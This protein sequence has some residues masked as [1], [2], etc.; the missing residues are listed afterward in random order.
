MRKK[1][2]YQIRDYLE[3]S[4]LMVIMFIVWL[5]AKEQRVIFSVLV[6]IFSLGS[7]SSYFEKVDST[8]KTKPSLKGKQ[9]EAKI[10]TLSGAFLLSTAIST[11]IEEPLF[12]FI[13]NSRNVQSVDLLFFYFIYALFLFLMSLCA[14]ELISKWLY[15]FALKKGWLETT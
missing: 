3:M 8:P 12:E 9:I 5:V 11:M 15:S 1:M 7:L 6:S 13:K 4:L 10:K 2:Q 14:V